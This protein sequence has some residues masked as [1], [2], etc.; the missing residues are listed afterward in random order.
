[1]HTLAAAS[2]LVL[3]GAVSSSFAQTA[4]TQEVIVL[5]TKVIETTEVIP[6]KM[7]TTPQSDYDARK[8]AVN[9]YAQWKIECRGDRACLDQARADYNAAMARLHAHR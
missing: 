9:S 4:Q 1:M 3:T 7:P 8:E 2:V 6:D 5:P